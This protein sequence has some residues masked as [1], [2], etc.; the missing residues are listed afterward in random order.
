MVPTSLAN[1]KLLLL[2]RS[3]CRCALAD[4]NAHARLHAIAALDY[5]DEPVTNAPETP[6]AQEEPSQSVEQTGPQA[7]EAVD[8]DD[9]ARAVDDM[10]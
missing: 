8:E 3:K 7:E 4:H 5:A 2:F 9:T 1:C 6:K 10:D